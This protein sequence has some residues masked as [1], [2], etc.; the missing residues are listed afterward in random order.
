VESKSKA[1]SLA[2][3]QTCLDNILASNEDSKV[4]DGLGILQKLIQNI[5]K[6]PTEDKF[7][8]LKKSNKTI[9]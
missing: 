6:N 9:A 5:L 1:Q 7:R 3:I 8:I 4:V 2:Q